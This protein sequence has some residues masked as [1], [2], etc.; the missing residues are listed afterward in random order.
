VVTVLCLVC[1]VVSCVCCVVLYL[2]LPINGKVHRSPACSRKKTCAL[3]NMM[4][5]ESR[6]VGPHFLNYT[7]LHFLLFAGSWHL[8][9]KYT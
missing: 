6:D 9:K 5:N 7:C 8:W 3:P 2:L 4:C 1:L